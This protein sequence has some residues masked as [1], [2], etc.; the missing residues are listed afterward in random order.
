MTKIRFKKVIVGTVLNDNPPGEMNTFS[1]VGDLNNDGRPDIVISGRNGRMVWLENTGKE[2]Q[3]PQHLIDEVDKMECGGSLWDLTGNGYLDIVNGGDWRSDEIYWWENPGAGGG[4]WTKRTIAQTGS[5]QFHDTVIGDVTGDGT[6]S[7]V[8]DNQQAPG[9]TAVYRVPLPANGVARDRAARDRV[10]RD[11]RMSPWPDLEVI[12]TGKTEPN[13]YR[14]SGVQPEEGLAIGDLDG[15]G[16]NELVCGTHWYKYLD[17]AWVG[18]KFATGY[19]TTKV[20]IGDVD[21]DGKNEIVLSEG[22]PCVYGKVQGGK[23]A[24][25]KP[26]GDVTDMWE[27]HVLE[28]GLL[29]AHSLQLGDIT[30]DGYLDILV[31][32]VGVADAETDSYVTRPPRI[33]VF[34]NQGPAAFQHKGKRSG[35]FSRHVV[36]EGTGIHDGLLVDMRNRGVLD[37]V[38]K[39]L[40]GEEKWNVHVYYNTRRPQR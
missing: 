12:A 33:L 40:H 30:G 17:G 26:K 32:E 10:A 11:P 28:D 1:N 21:A 34:E 25:F 23:V 3:W 13:P 29:D 9:G 38:G 27:E 8:F 37:I 2:E 36:D 7:L 15:D 6:M 16:Q 31:G 18:H 24:W 35:S 5:G 14:D 20:A 22:D 39:P 19:I 4:S